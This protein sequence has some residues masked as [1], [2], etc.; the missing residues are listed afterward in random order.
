VYVI[1]LSPAIFHFKVTQIRFHTVQEVAKRSCSPSSD[2]QSGAVH[3]EAA[4]TCSH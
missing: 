3:K 4:H 2:E 1:F